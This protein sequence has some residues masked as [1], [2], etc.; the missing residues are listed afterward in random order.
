MSDLEDE[1]SA[2]ASIFP[3]PELHI[4]SP[5][6][7]PTLT[8]ATP[9]G[10]A[11]VTLPPLYPRAA[12]HLELEGLRRGASAAVLAAWAGLAAPRV[13]AGEPFLFQLISE[14]FDLLRVLSV[15]A[16]PPAEPPAATAAASPPPPPRPYAGP[17]LY[18][19][20][21]IVERKSTFQAHVAR[22]AS[23]EAAAEALAEALSDARVARATHNCVAFRV[24]LP[25]G[26]LAA[27]CED[28][29]EAGMGRRLAQLLDDMGAEN[30]LLVVS[31]WYGG[32]LLGPSRFGVFANVGRA[33]LEAQ[34]W[35]E[36]R[37]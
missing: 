16:P 34:P 24:R 3:P 17:P 37:A 19:G 29:G 1:L 26:G 9:V 4:T 6:G 5:F 14:L 8:L 32:V 25:G 15:D 36:G 27:D 12:P 13:A 31:R 20:P 35:W 28:D 11:T 33:A 10:A 30:V 22:V 18:R 23:R 2:L 21:L 7:V